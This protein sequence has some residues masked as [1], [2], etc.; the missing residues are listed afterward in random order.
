MNRVRLCSCLLAF[1][2]IISLGAPARASWVFPAEYGYITT[3]QLTGTFYGDPNH[4]HGHFSEPYVEQQSTGLY[5]VYFPDISVLGPAGTVQVS[6][7]GNHGEY[8]KVGM[9]GTY[10][11]Y[12]EPEER[13]V[14]AYVACF[15]A[16]GSETNSLFSASYVRRDDLEN[17][18]VRFPGQETAYVFASQPS[19]S[20]YTAFDKNVPNDFAYN[21][22]GGSILISHTPGTG[23]YSVVLAGQNGFP[24]WPSPSVGGCDP[25]SGG[26]LEVTAYGFTNEYCKVASFTRRLGSTQVTVACFNGAGAP[27]ESY[28][29]LAYSTLSPTGSPSAAFAWAMQP[30]A[31]APYLVND[32]YWRQIVNTGDGNTC[33]HCFTSAPPISYFVRVTRSSQGMYD[34][35]FSEMDNDSG[36]SSPH[37][38]VTSFGSSSVRCEITNVMTGRP[39][40]GSLGAH[41]YV[42]CYSTTGQPA[43]QQ[44]MVTYSSQQ[45]NA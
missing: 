44:F 1:A 33:P 34:V 35:Y 14:Y 41:V 13:G 31:T 40:P 19:S 43:D 29:T 28:F 16:S 6:A 32:Y 37:V 11:R 42:G 2:A 17:N 12:S 26:T 15:S 20:S 36:I 39:S 18:G 22:T 25:Q 7:I 30:S 8:C 5:L 38:N 27:A 24:D 10:D 4:S 23:T 3:T 9:W 21:S 45:F